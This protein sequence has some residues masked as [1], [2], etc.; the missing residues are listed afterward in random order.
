MSYVS[1]ISKAQV[2][3]L[4]ELYKIAVGS[5]IYY[6]TSFVQDVIFN[7]NPYVAAPIKRGE[8]SFTEKLRAVRVSVSA[9]LYAPLIQFIA[10]AP[11]EDVAIT[12]YRA[13]KDAPDT[14][15]IQLFNGHVLDITIDKGIGTVNCES[16]TRLLRNKVP[17][18]VFQAYCNHMLFDSNCGLVEATYAVAGTITNITGSVIKAVAWDALAD[19]YFILGHANFGNDIR[20]ITNHVADALTL[21]IPFSGLSVG[22]T[23]TAYPGCDKSYE[24]CVGKFAASNLEHRLA[25]DNIPS[26]NPCI[27]G[28]KV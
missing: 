10:S 5:T 1:R 22:G 6:Y 15:Y 14:D 8:F 16:E 3:E 2:S 7:S 20:L 21:Q 27:F 9:P 26:S 19:G 17:K 23:V 28:F 12:I 11:P 25:F 24:T 13:F 18:F 4:A